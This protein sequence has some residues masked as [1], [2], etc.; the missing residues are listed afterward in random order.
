M[1]VIEEKFN[2]EDT[3]AFLAVSEEASTYHNR[4]DTMDDT[5]G[6]GS[7]EGMEGVL[8]Q[9]I[10]DVMGG[11]AKKSSKVAL[12]KRIIRRMIN[13]GTTP[14][15][16]AAYLERST[17]PSL[18]LAKIYNLSNRDKKKILSVTD[19]SHTMPTTD[20]NVEGGSYDL[21]GTMGGVMIKR[22]FKNTT[23]E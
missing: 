8:N 20:H 1:V 15:V 21:G 14:V 3:G 23:K 11:S 22:P 12:R 7:I 13:G 9:R 2:G 18:N 5:I 6:K 17:S 16:G 19:G 10:T 4:N